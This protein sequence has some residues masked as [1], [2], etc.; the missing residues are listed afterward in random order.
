MTESQMNKLTNMNMGQLLKEYS[1]TRP[2]K[3]DFLEAEIMQIDHDRILVDLGAKTDAVITPREYKQTDEKILKNLSEGDLVDVYVLSSPT[4]LQKPR[5]SLQR[6]MERADWDQAKNLMKEGTVSAYEIT[7]KNKGGLLVQFGHIE[8]FLP[9]SLMPSVSRAPNRKVAEETKSNL[10]GEEVYLKVIQADSRKKK[11]IFSA[12]EDEDEITLKRLANLKP[13]D[14]ASGIV[15]NLVDYGAFI[16]LFGIDGLLHISEME[17]GRTD[18]P[19][20]ILNYGDKLEVKILEIDEEN[21]RVSLSRKALVDPME[22]DTI[23]LQ[24]S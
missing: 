10:V 13:G 6:G 5:V 19:S 15:V 11:L 12:R 16:D 1:Y 9:A 24:T 4:M 7:G 8:G 21:N 17:Y 18:H 23:E 3:G 22:Q 14:V 2:E 20:D